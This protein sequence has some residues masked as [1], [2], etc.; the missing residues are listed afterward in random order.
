MIINSLLEEQNI[1][2]YRLAKN[3]GIPYTTVNDI[4]NGKAQLKKCSAE[5]IYRLAKELNVSMEVLLEPYLVKRS[6]FELFKSH[7]CHE[8][9]ELGD[10]NFI[11][12]TLKQD[13]ILKYYRRNWYPECLYLLAMLDYISNLNSVPLCD[14]YDRLRKCCLQKPIYPASL[15]AAAQIAKNDS[16]LTDARKEAIPE[17]LHFNIIE[18]EVRNV[19]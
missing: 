8:L 11:I 17:F 15:W 3:S 9:K 1:T 16:M 13:D 5:T 12:K 10:I 2:K 18:S 4:C 19:I 6:G 14:K 7:I